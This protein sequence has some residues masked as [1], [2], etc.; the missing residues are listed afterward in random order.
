MVKLFIRGG[1][2]TGIVYRRY[3]ADGT[4]APDGR[5][6]RTVQVDMGRYYWGV[7]DM[8]LADKQGTWRTG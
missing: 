2:E 3:D 8:T 6:R 5:Y 1:P 7:A 4:E